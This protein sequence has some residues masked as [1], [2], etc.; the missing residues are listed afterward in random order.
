MKLYRVHMNTNGSQTWCCDVYTSIQVGIQHHVITCTHQWKCE[1]NKILYRVISIQMGVEY[2][3]VHINT[4][5]SWTWRCNVYTSRQM[6][7]EHGN[8]GNNKITEHRAIFQRE[9]QIS[10][11]VYTSIQMEVEHDDVMCTHQDRWESNM[12][13]YRVHI[14][15]GGSQTWY[16]NLYTS[17]RMGVEHKVV[18]VAWVTRRM[19][20]K[21]Q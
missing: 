6:G 7:D 16:C 15:T 8:K 2:D 1:S 4:D 19:S 21:K 20:Y 18:S 9:I 3:D 10:C 14:K 17:I 11:N 12:I 13:L 5:G